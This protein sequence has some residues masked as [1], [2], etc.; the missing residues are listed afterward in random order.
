MTVP[1]LGDGGARPAGGLIA[2]RRHIARL[3]ASD[4]PISDQDLDARIGLQLGLAESAHSWLD[5]LATYGH[6]RIGQADLPYSLFRELFR[7]LRLPAGAVLLDL[8]SGYGRPAFYGAL[9]RN[10]RVHGI[11]LVR[12]RVAEALRVRNRLDLASL[13]FTCGD[14]VTAPWP[15]VR[16]YSVLNSFLPSV[17]PAVVAR[18]REAARRRQILVASVS[19][20]NGA[21]AAQPWLVEVPPL[22][23][24]CDSLGLRLF[25]SR[26]VPRAGGDG[27]TGCD[28]G[29][30]GAGGDGG[31][32]GDGGT[33]GG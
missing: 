1:A 4:E 8:G 11:E 20:S 22:A 10:A 29:D 24:P 30:G 15:E 19:T 6:H 13:D 16:H 27:G 18:L 28:G 14:A 32:G 23:G 21:F 5:L 7:R 12:E 2:L 17:L 26:R 9:L 31:D 33:G 25:A 3:H